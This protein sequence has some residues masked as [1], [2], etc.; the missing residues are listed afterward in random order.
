MAEVAR[1]AGVHPATVSRAL[2]D[3]PR[4]T[5]AVRAEIR[6]VAT[7][8]GYRR[9][10]LVAALMSVRRSRAAAGYQATLAFVTHY[11]PSRAAFFKSSFGQ[12]LAGARLRARI[13]GYTVEEFNLCQPGLA[14]ARATEILRNRGITGLIVAPLHSINEPVAL[15]WSHFATVAIGHSLH[16]VPVH[17]VTH[18]H[19]SALAL[20]CRQGRAAGRLRPGLVL[21]RRV[22]EKV[23]R[24]WVAAL[25]LD[26]SEHPAA[27]PVPPFL[28]IEWDEAGFAA[29]YRRHRP[30]PILT[31][32][33]QQVLG[34]L[35]R[36]GVRPPATGIVSLDRR[37]RERT[38]AGIEQDYPAMGAA[39]VD[40]LIGYLQRHETGLPA[41]PITVTLEGSWI[42]GAS[43]RAQPRRTLRTAP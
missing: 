33:P 15:D 4:I 40:L 7:R 2:R 14:P 18:N 5:A 37:P 13:S 8:L 36:L 38:L 35:A 28:P 42:A 31:V 30:D 1:A 23:E 21:P 29:W 34:A 17:R 11:P 24:R 25:L 41:R 20:A 9:N 43:L 19:F 39:A 22:H 16:D 10:P 26:Q 6:A 12:L 32:R 27:A 3:D